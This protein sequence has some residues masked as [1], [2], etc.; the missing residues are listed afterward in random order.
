MKRITNMTVSEYKKLAR[1]IDKRFGPNKT[2]DELPLARK[3]GRPAKGVK[4]HV[5]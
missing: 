3:P 4:C 2:W 5:Q 1:R